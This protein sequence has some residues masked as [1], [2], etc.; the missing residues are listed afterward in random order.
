[1]TDDDDPFAHFNSKDSPTI[2]KPAAGRAG[3]PAAAPA[4]AMPTPLHEAG[5]GHAPRGPAHGLSPGAA[6]QGAAEAPTSAGLNPLLQHAAPLLMAATRLRGTAQH[7]NPAALRSAL[8]DTVRH[9]E[10]NARAA[11]VPNEQVVAARYVLCTF[12][13]QCATSTPWG[14]SGAW[15]SHSLLVQ[16]HNE[17]WGGEKVFQLL[18]KVGK[19]VGANRWLLELMHAVLALG[20]EGRY[21]GL[22]N[23]RAQLD[24]IRER[25]ATLLRQ[26]GAPLEAELSPQWQ[27]AASTQ[28]LRDGIPLWVVAALAAGVLLVL[29]FILQFTLNSRTNSIFNAL[30][31]ID[32]KTAPAAPRPPPVAAVQPRLAVLLRPQIE[33]RQLQVADLADRSIVTISGDGFFESS[34]AEVI[35]NVRP[36]LGHVA[37][38][39]AQVPGSVLVTGH[40]DNQP[41]RSLRFP[42]NWHLSQARAE[43]V[44]NLLAPTVPLDRMKAEGR[45][46]S[47]PLD[48]NNT[49]TGRARNRR[50]EVTLFVRNN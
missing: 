38:A 4:P 30:Q 32:V 37:Q 42:S 13:D 28:R 40:S 7:P 20:F 50:V 39:L 43:T 6:S 3:R 25:L 10:S 27:G 19:D 29:F 18:S 35:D 14:G 49:A 2:I 12:V 16:F 44:R 17:A 15:N 23:G 36:L 34:R 8:A 33:A 41:I 5:A 45:A 24:T 31:S 22:D 11:G 9:F 46:E 48:D 21:R 26:S 47:E 1:M